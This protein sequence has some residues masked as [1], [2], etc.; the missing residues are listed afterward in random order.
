M[1]AFL[2][3]LTK[4]L[5]SFFL[6]PL[7]WIVMALFTLMNAFLFSSQVR[8]LGIAPSQFSL[9]QQ[10]FGSIWFF[11]SFFFLFPLITM[12]LFAEERKLGTLEGL[13]TAPV[14][15]ITVL[16]AKYTA[17]V[18]LYLVLIAPIFLFFFVFTEVTGEKAAFHSGAFTGAAFALFLIG[19]FHIAVGIFASS[20]TANQLIA[21][22]VTFVVVMLHFFFGFLRS[23]ISVPNSN[24]ADG[25]DYISMIQHMNTFATGLIDSRVIVYYLSLTVLLLFLTHAVLDF[26]KWKT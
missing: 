10:M 23:M 2:V 17:T 14:R 19:L 8:S 15:T 22:M 5:R 26:R 9:V 7:A 12:R 24:Y 3:L 21:A 13:F 11:M 18:I 20:L 16:L 4:E 25:L 6:S 1:S